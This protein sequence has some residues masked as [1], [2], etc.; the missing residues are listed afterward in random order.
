MYIIINNLITPGYIINKS[1]AGKYYNPRNRHGFPA[2]IAGF[3]P[4]VFGPVIKQ[5]IIQKQPIPNI[6]KRNIQK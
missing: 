1:N 6:F 2:K 5:N 4:D 3:C